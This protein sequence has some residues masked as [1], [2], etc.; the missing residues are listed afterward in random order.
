M[1]SVMF[2]RY[3]ERIAK[4]MLNEFEKQLKPDLF[5]PENENKRL[6]EAAELAERFVFVTA[7]FIEKGL[8]KNG[9]DAVFLHIFQPNI[10]GQ[11][12]AY[13]AG[14]LH[15]MTVATAYERGIASASVK[16]YSPSVRKR[17][18]SV[19]ESESTFFD[20][21]VSA[22]LIESA[23]Y[24][25]LGNFR[26][27]EKI[28][29]KIDAAI[30]KRVLKNNYLFKSVAYEIDL[31]PND[32]V[33]LYQV[34]HAI[35]LTDELQKECESDPYF[36]RR[37]EQLQYFKKIN[38]DESFHWEKS[39]IGDDFALTLLARIAQRRNVDPWLIKALENALKKNDISYDIRRPNTSNVYPIDYRK[40]K[41][42]VAKR[43]HL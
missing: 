20:C 21:A 14:K 31:D 36:V 23:Y 22:S 15:K 4:E 5:T 27:P 38:S 28:A 34:N 42:P 19:G 6:E 40:R 9:R 35:G 12:E 3:K 24:T 30:M 10:W 13:K 11:D 41:R 17:L 33:A 25:R 7:P 26:M 32:N 1:A 8:M 37:E 43:V 29:N 18:A 2:E 39:K 16:I